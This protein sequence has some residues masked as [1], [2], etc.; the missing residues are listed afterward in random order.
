MYLLQQVLYLNP[1]CLTISRRLLVRVV[2][3]LPR[4][5]LG[6]MVR[7]QQ[8]HRNVRR[9]GRC[10][11]RSFVVKSYL[12]RRIFRLY[13]A[14]VGEL[15]RTDLQVRFSETIH[16]RLGMH[17]SV[18]RQPPHRHVL[19]QTPPMSKSQGSSSLSR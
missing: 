18:D 1:H 12:L 10:R 3:I 13:H 11:S 17:Q 2:I 6:Q 16:K 5:L 9:E 8:L 14:K 4:H 19:P 7:V 15:A